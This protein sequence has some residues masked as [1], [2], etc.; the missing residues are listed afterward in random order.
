MAS[1][2]SDSRGNRTV[3]FMGKDG[4]RRSV[5]LGKVSRKQAVAVKLKVED[6][7]AA[8][9]T[10]H[11]ASDETSRWVAGLDATLRDRLAAVGVGEGAAGHGT[12]RV[13]GRLSRK[14]Q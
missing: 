8:S 9:I 1:I 12:R 14:T 7:A 3:Q 2:S 11:T 10:G 13:P 5:R 4:R 6:L